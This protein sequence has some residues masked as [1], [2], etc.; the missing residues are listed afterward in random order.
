MLEAQSANLRHGLYIRLWLAQ[1]VRPFGPFLEC[2]NIASI[3]TLC[4]TNEGRARDPEMTTCEAY[5]ALMC[6]TKFKPSQMQDS[7]RSQFKIVRLFQ[8]SSNIL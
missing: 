5:V 2:L 4:P 3:E 7:L 8:Q 1:R 6:Q